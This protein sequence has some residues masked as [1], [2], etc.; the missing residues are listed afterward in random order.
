MKLFLAFALAL[1]SASVKMGLELEGL[2]A[3]GMAAPE[4]QTML[5]SMQEQVK[6]L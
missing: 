6:A 4:R 3:E 1:P 5:T 2:K